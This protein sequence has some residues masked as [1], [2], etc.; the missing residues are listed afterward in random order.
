MLGGEPERGL[1]LLND[2][3]EQFDSMGNSDDVS[4]VDVLLAEC[5]LLLGDPARSLEIVA[6]TSATNPTRLPTLE[7]TRGRALQAL[8]DLDGASEAF[9]GSLA[10][11]REQDARYEVAR[12]LDALTHL[13]VLRGD[14]ATA[15]H[16]ETESAELFARLGIRVEP[17]DRVIDV[18][19]S[20]LP[21]TAALRT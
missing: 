21:T 2:A 19:T 11:A 3:R 5:H 4:E 12:T 18:R 15:E 17:G 16:H 8:G 6:A 14:I 1:E 7:R 10:E 20:D 13:D 9:A